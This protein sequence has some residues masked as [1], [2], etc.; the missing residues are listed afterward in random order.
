MASSPL[1]RLVGLG[2]LAGAAGLAYAAGI[3]VRA[4]TLR[5]VEVP[6]LPPG[7]HPIRV[8]HLSD[9]HV[10]PH[11]AHKLAWLE[12]LARLDPDLWDVVTSE[13]RSRTAGT[14]GG[15]EA[16]LHDVVVRAVRR[17]G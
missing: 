10:T 16:T 3:E 6:V 14:P 5:R 17:R 1:A 2:A 9:L 13:E 4:F 15:R 12:S 8:L 11:Q 7:S